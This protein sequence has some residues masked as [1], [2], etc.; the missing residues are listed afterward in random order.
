MLNQFTLIGRM[1]KTPQLQT[2]REGVPYIRYT[3]A[4][5][6]TFKNQLGNYDTDFIQLVSWN[7]LAETVAD[8]CTKGSLISVNGRIQMRSLE[9]DNQK[10]LTIPD[11]IAETVTFLQLKRLENKNQDVHIPPKPTSY[12]E[13]NSQ[14][15]TQS[16]PS[17][18][19]T[20]E[21]PPNIEFPPSEEK[22]Q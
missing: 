22:T 5:R 1:A 21:T 13:Q 18:E 16:K 12:K 9:T 20:F 10:R 15:D 7:K 6:R 14:I 2:T 17:S 4:V 8:Y 3:L 11:V 19:P